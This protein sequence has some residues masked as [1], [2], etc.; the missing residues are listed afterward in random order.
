[1]L[2]IPTHEQFSLQ[3]VPSS[4]S[5]QTGDVESQKSNGKRNNIG[6]IF[7]ASSRYR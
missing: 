4:S 3:Y 2:K 6:M 7:K 5:L 1:M